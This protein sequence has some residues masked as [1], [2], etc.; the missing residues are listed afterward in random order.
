MFTPGLFVLGLI[1]AHLSGPALRNRFASLA[2]RRPPRT[3]ELLSWT[4]TLLMAGAYALAPG[5]WD[6]LEASLAMKAIST[7]GGAAVYAGPDDALRTQLVYGPVPLVL[8]AVVA[9]LSTAPAQALKVFTGLIGLL[10]V[11]LPSA[12][13]R[14]ESEGSERA[15]EAAW[16]SFLVL[17]GLLLFRAI[18]FRHT[19]DAFLLLGCSLWALGIIRSGSGFSILLCGAGFGIALGTKIHGPVYL[20]PVIPWAITRLGIPATIGSMAAGGL[21]AL[22]PFLSPQVSLTNFLDGLSVVGTHQRLPEL[23]WRNLG[24]AAV[25]VAPAAL[26][27]ASLREVSRTAIHAAW[28]L[29]LAVVTTAFVGSKEGGGMHHMLPWVILGPALWYLAG[30]R[31]ADTAPAMP[32]RANLW[33]PRVLFAWCLVVAVQG[34]M[35]QRSYIAFLQ[36]PPEPIS[37]EP[38]VAALGTGTHSVALGFTDDARYGTMVMRPYLAPVVTVDLF[39]PLS[40]ADMARGQ[41]PLGAST[42]KLIADQ[43]IDA[44]VLP[45]EGEPFSMRSWY[46]ETVLLFGDTLPAVFLDNYYRATTVGRFSVWRAKRLRAPTEDR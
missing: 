37:L 5:Y 2:T 40:I 4:F 33:A 8:P 17:A 25:L 44:F 39:D 10:A 22:A 26:R 46:D 28:L 7:A 9:L 43:T 32:P 12:W 29:A 30:D 18:P 45:A 19:T 20:L 36:S 14:R 15:T 41:R 6:H 16:A 42:V 31:Q 27:L 24:L 21:L 13:Q 11:L 35:T 38:L 23:F 34:A 1:L 3:L